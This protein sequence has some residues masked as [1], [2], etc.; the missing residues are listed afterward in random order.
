MNPKTLSA[1]SQL[2]D[3]RHAAFEA[4]ERKHKYPALLLFYSFIDICAA[5]SDES[6]TKD[7][8]A[9]FEGFLQRYALLSWKSFR[10]YEL[11]AA[12]SSLLHAYSPFGNHTAKADGAKPIFYY[13]YPET[14][15]EM[16]EALDS[17]GHSD[18]ILLDITTIK[19]VAVSCFN[20]M[21]S[22]VQSEAT[23][24]QVFLKNAEN[25][26]QD[27]FQI[28]LEKELTLMSELIALREEIAVK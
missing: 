15:P 16:R 3:L 23:F 18:Y 21:W 14:A 6:Q 27:L 19:H 12:R 26:L 20:S 13:A 5:L 8:R 28:R 4:M 25:L 10:P 2:N 22:R 11:W 9:R 17:K 24:E 7:N 1:L